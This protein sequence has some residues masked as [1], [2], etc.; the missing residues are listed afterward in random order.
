MS[1]KIFQ[2]KKSHTPTE[3]PL[4]LLKRIL[5]QDIQ[6]LQNWIRYNITMKHFYTDNEHNDM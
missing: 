1:T 2:I 5:A 4:I 6:V 3:Y